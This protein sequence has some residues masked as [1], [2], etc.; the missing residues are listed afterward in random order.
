MLLVEK[1]HCLVLTNSPNFNEVA[2]NKIELTEGRK[3][4]CGKHDK[5]EGAVASIPTT[6]A[7]S[8]FEA[9]R[10]ATEHAR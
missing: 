3:C 5:E 4:G 9:L 6:R 7:T 1:N 10:L 8:D 2:G